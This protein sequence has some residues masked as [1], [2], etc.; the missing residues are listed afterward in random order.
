[1]SHRTE[2]TA[3]R[4]LANIREIVFSIRSGKTSGFPTSVWKCARLSPYLNISLPIWQPAPRSACWNHDTD[5][6]KWQKTDG[7]VTE[8]SSFGANSTH[9]MLNSVFKFWVLLH[10][11]L[12]LVLYS[13]FTQDWSE[14]VPMSVGGVWCVHCSSYLCKGRF[15]KSGYTC[16]AP[17]GFRRA[18]P[19]EHRWHTAQTWPTGRRGQSPPAGPEG[20]GWLGAGPWRAIHPPYHK[21]HLRFPPG[22]PLPNTDC[23]ECLSGGG[24]KMALDKSQTT[25]ERDGQ[26]KTGLMKGGKMKEKKESR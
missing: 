3:G 14:N 13:I 18:V 4:K 1:M 2:K 5:S 6:S 20:R 22:P 16:C 21:P 25:K 15:V 11:W 7:W 24:M 17:A 12:I 9:G 8:Q 19:G 10:Y 26:N 23:P